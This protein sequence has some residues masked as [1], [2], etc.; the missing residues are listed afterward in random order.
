MELHSGTV[1]STWKISRT[2]RK[3]LRAPS[4]TMLSLAGLHSIA[5]T[6]RLGNTLGGTY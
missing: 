6:I 4:A 2:E 3:E 1:E 5:N